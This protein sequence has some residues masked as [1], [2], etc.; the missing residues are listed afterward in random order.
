MKVNETRTGALTR[1]RVVEAALRVMDEEGLDAVSMRRVAR[2]VGVEAM[3]LYHHVEDKEDLLDGICEHVMAGF[4][5]P[6]PSRTGRRTAGEE[7]ARGVAC[8][9]RIRRDAPLRRATRPGA[10]GGLDAPDGVRTPAPPRRGPLRPRHRASVPCVRRLHPGVRDDGAR[11]D[12]GRIRRGAPEGPRGPGV[13]PPGR[14][15]SA[16]CGIA[17][18]RR[19][20]RRR[21][22]RVRTRSVDQRPRGQAARNG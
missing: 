16:R 22:V 19:M 21:A 10:H 9:R 11:L 18:L 7:P 3:S 15:R 4:E 2:E 8:C 17:V 1:E 13:G 5:F 14:V 12:R 6:I 20:R